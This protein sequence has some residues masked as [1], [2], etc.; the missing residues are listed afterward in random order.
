MQQRSEE[1]REHILQAAEQLFAQNGYDATGVAQICAAAQVSKGAF[2][3]HFPSKQAVFLTLLE[4]WL[5]GLEPQI[6][7]FVRQEESIPGALLQMTAI[8]EQVF[9][10]GKGQLPM[11]LEFWVQAS[12][13]PAVWQVT[14]APYYR[15]VER[16]AAI[17]QRGMQA[18]S[19]RS[20]DS[21]AAARMV[22]ALAIGMIVQG[23]FD[24]EGADWQQVSKQGFATLI[25]GMQGGMQ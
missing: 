3:H 15:Y 10:A 9:T 17:L 22:M 13:D 4:N 12:R 19:L 7:A 5:S 25:A 16:F 1:T 8:F 24:P 6:E 14:I 11:F 23:L 20:A 2:Y 21:G 18:G